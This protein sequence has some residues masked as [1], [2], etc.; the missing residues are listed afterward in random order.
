[1]YQTVL[2]TQGGT[3]TL[4]QS[5]SSNGDAWKE[6][7]LQLGPTTIDK[8][9]YS[10]QG[11]YITDFFVTND[12]EFTKNNV[13]ICAPLIRIFATQKLS[14]ETLTKVQFQSKLREYSNQMISY[15]ENVFNNLMLYLRKDLPDISFLPEGNI[16][17]AIDGNLV[18]TQMWE[19]FK[20]DQR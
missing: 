7:L 9:A 2:P 1:M 16:K 20:D 15:Q 3:T 11:S 18:K 17:S 19:M 14:D 5:F 8:L 6:L 13:K 12:I 10:D 4:I